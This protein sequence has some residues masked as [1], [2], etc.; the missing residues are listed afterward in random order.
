M[1]TNSLTRIRCSVLALLSA[2]ML[3]ACGADVVGSAATVGTL[4]A[5]QAAQAKATEAQILSQLKDAQA[6]AAVRDAS[7]ADAGN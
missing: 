4:Q 1:A 3:V 6:V 5:Q 2:V 7:A